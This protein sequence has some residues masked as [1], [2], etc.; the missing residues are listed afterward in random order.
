MR[1]HFYFIWPDFTKFMI[2]Y[3]IT[4]HFFENSVSRWIHCIVYVVFG[5]LVSL[6]G[7]S[8]FRLEHNNRHDCRC[9]RVA[10]GGTWIW[11]YTLMWYTPIPTLI[12]P[13]TGDFHKVDRV[14]FTFG[15]GVG[16][17]ARARHEHILRLRSCRHVRLRR[18]TVDTRRVQGGRGRDQYMST[19]VLMADAIAGHLSWHAFRQY[20]LKIISYK[21]TC[22][23]NNYAL[24]VHT[25]S[26]SDLSRMSVML[27]L[28]QLVFL[29]TNDVCTMPAKCKMT[30][31]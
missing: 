29:L 3:K 16:T 15:V 17:C 14:R 22:Y 8:R 26:T 11:N 9:G 19:H 28:H 6:G 13:I 23:A 10:D 1:P 12:F 25:M 31:Q 30:A 20:H 27:L 5:Y 18:L 2:E 21:W 7:V 24:L 4:G